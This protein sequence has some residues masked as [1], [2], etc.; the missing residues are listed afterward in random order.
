M[1]CLMYRGR[2]R[3]QSE[4]WSIPLVCTEQGATGG[5]FQ[6][7]FACWLSQSN[8]TNLDVTF[9]QDIVSATSLVS[10]GPKGNLWR[11]NTMQLP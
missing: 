10:S 5:I 7:A 9:R 6:E 11:V 8:F 4:L 3:L 1:C 2:S